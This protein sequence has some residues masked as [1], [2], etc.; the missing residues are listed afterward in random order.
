M[1][2]LRIGDSFEM[3]YQNTEFVF[4]VGFLLNLLLGH[5]VAG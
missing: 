2:F 1:T 5:Q 4:N 3:I